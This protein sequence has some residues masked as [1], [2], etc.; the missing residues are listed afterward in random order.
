MGRNRVELTTHM[1]L[2]Q[3][4]EVKSYNAVEVQLPDVGL[5]KFMLISNSYSAQ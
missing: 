5:C 3:Y 2:Y 1:K 4:I